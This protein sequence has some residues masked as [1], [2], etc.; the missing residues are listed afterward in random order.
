MISTND[1]GNTI[2]TW[3]NKAEFNA[4]KYKHLTENMFFCYKN[5]NF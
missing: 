2:W 1:Q 4:W 5:P 3:I